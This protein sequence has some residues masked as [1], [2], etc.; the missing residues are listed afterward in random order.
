M[1]EIIEHGD[2]INLE[3][4][5]INKDEFNLIITN[6]DKES[7]GKLT[8]N[9]HNPKDCC[10]YSMYICEKGIRFERYVH[11]NHD[12]DDIESLQVVVDPKNT[13]MKKGEI[14]WNSR[15]PYSNEGRDYF[16]IPFGSKTVNY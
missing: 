8:L 1:E 10:E 6:F 14:L 12:H 3:G 2:S 7:N 4:V 5:V 16:Y 15:G 9:F 13:S 11:R